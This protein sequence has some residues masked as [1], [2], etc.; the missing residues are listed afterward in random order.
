MLPIQSFAQRDSVVCLT[1]KQ[2][3]F[4]LKQNVIAKG[5]QIDTALYR[6]QLKGY[7]QMVILLDQ[8]KDGLNFALKQAVQSSDNYRLSY[9][10]L[11]NK[12]DKKVKWNVRYKKI[13]AGL[14]VFVVAEAAL[15]YLIAK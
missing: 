8:E 4:F 7:D 6:A 10:T 1:N 5:L 2:V 3:K 11:Q 9:S 15:I 12:Y 14:S 13:I